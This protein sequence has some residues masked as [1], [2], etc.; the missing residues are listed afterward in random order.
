MTYMPTNPLPVAHGSNGGFGGGG[1]WSYNINSNANAFNMSNGGFGGGGSRTQI[2]SSNNRIIRNSS[3]GGFGGGAGNSVIVGGSGL[4]TIENSG[5]GGFGGGG[6]SR[7][8]ISSNDRNCS[9]GGFGGGHAHPSSSRGGGGAGLGGAIFANVGVNLTLENVI[10]SHNNATGG[11]GN[12][13]GAGLGGAIFVREGAQLNIKGD[14][15]IN[16]N[17]VIGGTGTN[18]GSA[19]GSGIFLQ[20]SSGTTNSTNTITSTLTFAPGMGETQILDDIIADQKGCVPTETQGWGIT[21]EGEGNLI[22]L[23]PQTYSGDTLISEGTLQIGNGTKDANL[24]GNIINEAELV[25]YNPNPTT[26]EGNISGNGTLQKEGLQPFILTGHKTGTGITTINGGTLQI[27]NGVMDGSIAGDI[28]NNTTLAFHPTI[29][30]MT[31][32]GAISGPG[33]VRKDGDQD[34]ILTGSIDG[35]PVTINNGNLQIGNGGTLGNVNSNFT[36]NNASS[37]LIFNHSNNA[38]LTGNTS[39]GGSLIK[40]GPGRLNLTNPLYHT[41]DTLI[42]AGELRVNTTLTSNVTVSNG[43][44][45][46]GDAIVQNLIN[47]GV[48]APGNPGTMLQ[49]TSFSNSNGIYKVEVNT[50]GQSTQL[51]VTDIANLGGTLNVVPLS[52]NYQKS[53]A[54]TYTILT[55]QNGFN[56]TT[57]TTIS[58]SPLYSYAV[59]Y[60]TTSFPPSVIL[61]L[62]KKSI[63]A[64]LA[65]AGNGNAIA[66]NLDSLSSPT[67]SLKKAMTQLATIE[68]TETFN[69][70]VNQL[71]NA[72]NGSLNQELAHTFFDSGDAVFKSVQPSSLK[73]LP[74]HEKFAKLASAVNFPITTTLAQL[75][76][77]LVPRPTTPLLLNSNTSRNLAPLFVRTNFGQSSLW[78]NSSFKSVHQDAYQS[79]GSFIPKLSLTATGTQIGGDHR[80]LNNLLLGFTASYFH[81]SYHLD[82]NLGQGRV[83]TYQ[84]GL[85]GSV[86]LTPQ[87]YINLLGSY[88][89]NRFNGTRSINFSNF[90]A[91]SSQQHYSNQWGSMTESGYKIS[92]PYKVALT[93]LVNLGILYSDE[94]KY[95]E[96]GSGTVGLNVKS[97]NRTF[98]NTKVG[99]QL[100]KHF[101]TNEI[102]FYAFA[103]L[104]YSQQRGLNH[105]HKTT[106]SFIGQIATFVVSSNKKPEK[107]VSPSVGLT[108]LWANNLHATIG[109]KGDFSD[110]RQAHAGFL[111]IG[112][113]F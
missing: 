110:Q 44:T 74:S 13:G 16:D 104:A 91:R 77:P 45:L 111:R 40:R 113:N 112:K 106:A 87:W 96:Q 97:Q 14:F 70:A 24:L 62:T 19:F 32:T 83:N 103:K 48:V 73:E 65:P 21:K 101:K 100:D 90:E 50:T 3:N 12:G 1:A 71:G 107:L 5:N 58:P 86:N 34:L 7:S 20:G 92:L 26:Y 49:A 55:A 22:I 9:Q 108:A 43:A 6:G 98:L 75:F 81:T 54:Y 35:N 79:P 78:I 69:H 36:F 68:E 67:G 80:F 18:P 33:T 52:G 2:Q 72:S 66:H 94:S 47:N 105:S 28:V 31:Y 88:A 10:L 76:R 42:E 37:Q 89:Y 84:M 63:L 64:S 53:Q 17:T 95:R 23:G 99:V 93:P 8:P 4:T 56:D 11:L 25:F 61:T 29:A 60:D 51:Q 82:K 46:S 30:P 102:Q 59:T 27:G 85:Y 38:V 57:F 15:G 41:R 109:Y 39:G